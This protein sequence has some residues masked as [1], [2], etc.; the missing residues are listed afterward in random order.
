MNQNDLTKLIGQNIKKYRIK[1]N[2]YNEKM[3]VKKLAKLANL[4][5]TEIIKIENGNYKKN[6]SIEKLYKI[7]IILE[8]PIN[9]FFEEKYDR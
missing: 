8:T 4:K 6:I 1:Y 5:E 3:T 9:K 2:K 7:S